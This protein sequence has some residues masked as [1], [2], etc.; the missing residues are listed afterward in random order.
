MVNALLINKT[1]G[2]MTVGN[3]SIH[4]GD[5][6]TWLYIDLNRITVTVITLKL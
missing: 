1:V 6:S 5:Q 4:F 3:A 2:E